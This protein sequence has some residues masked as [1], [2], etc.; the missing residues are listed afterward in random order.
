MDIVNYDK[1]TKKQKLQWKIIT[2]SISIIFLV[3]LSW[4]EHEAP[5][6]LITDVVTAIGIISYSHVIVSWIWQCVILLPNSIQAVW[7]SRMI[8]CNN[9]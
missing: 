8:G 4:I 3:Y 9:P 1:K 2:S 6:G 5:L 7:Y